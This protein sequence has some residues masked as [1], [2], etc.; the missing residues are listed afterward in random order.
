M[1]IAQQILDG[2]EEG[3]RFS[4]YAVLYRTNAQSNA[5]EQ[6]FS[7]SGV[8]HRIIGGHRFYDREEIKDMTAYLRVIDNPNDNVRLTRIINVPKRGIGK[9]TMDRAGELAALSGKSVYEIIRNASDYPEISRAASKFCPRAHIIPRLSEKRKRKR[10]CQNRE[11]RG[12]EIQ[13]Y[14]V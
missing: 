3:R 14:K 10:R 1:Y 9:T 5:I 12:V 8:P 7:R 4:D 13:Y 11:H 6:A 2:V